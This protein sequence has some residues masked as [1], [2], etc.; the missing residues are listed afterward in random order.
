MVSLENVNKLVT[1]YDVDVRLVKH[2]SDRRSLVDIVSR[3]NDRIVIELAFTDGGL[4]EIY[5]VNNQFYELSDGEF[6]QLLVDLLDGA[7][8]IR[9]ASNKRYI[10]SIHGIG[11]ERT[12]KMGKSDYDLYEILPQVLRHPLLRADQH[13]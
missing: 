11:P 6:E 1:Q 8:K 13:D 10:V 3:C 9:G 7:Y 12:V 5:F 4:S 2:K